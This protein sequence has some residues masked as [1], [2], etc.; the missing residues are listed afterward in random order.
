MQPLTGLIA[1]GVCGCAPS[2]A[3]EWVST[4]RRTRSASP[5]RLSFPAES[6]KTMISLRP[7]TLACI[8]RHCPASEM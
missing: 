3:G 8:T 2:T 5:R 4:Q 6:R 1:P 7:A